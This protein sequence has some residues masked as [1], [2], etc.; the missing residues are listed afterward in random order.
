VLFLCEGWRGK[1]EK[2]QQGPGSDQHGV[3]HECFLP[4]A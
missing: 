3:F 4:Y 1:S 2:Q